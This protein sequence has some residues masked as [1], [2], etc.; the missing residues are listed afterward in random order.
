MSYL[1]KNLDTGNVDLAKINAD[2]GLLD[3]L[4]EVAMLGISRSYFEQSKSILMDSLALQPERGRVLIGL[5][6]FCIANKEFDDAVVLFQDLLK[7]NPKNEYAKVH[8][9]LAYWHLKNFDEA[10]K[11]LNEV[12]TDKGDDSTVMLARAILDEMKAA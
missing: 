5:G 11:T 4:F 9:G 10:K 7:Q 2:E 3:L 1:Q 12:I 6:L 8:L